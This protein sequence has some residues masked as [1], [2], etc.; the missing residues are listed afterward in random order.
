LKRILEAL[1]EEAAHVV[2]YAERGRGKTSLANTAVERLR[3]VGAMVGRHVCSADSDF[4]QIIHGILRDLPT[5]LLPL[6]P[7][8][9]GENAGRGCDSILP[10]RGLRPADVAE[11]PRRL[12]CDR[13]IF[14]VDEF[15]RVQDKTTRTRL[16][17]T[18]K[19]LSDRGL[20][21]LFM[22]IGVSNT[23]EQIIGQHPSIQRNIA[24]IHL[25]LLH[26][27][28]VR[29]MLVR[30]GKTGGVDFSE[31][32]CGVVAGI[33]RGMPYIAQLMGL[34]I[35]QQTLARGGTQTSAQDV[36]AAVDRLLADQ[37][38]EVVTR[39]AAL[40]SGPRG[41]AMEMALSRVA[42]APQDWL[43]RI[44][45][46]SMEPSLVTALLQ[47][48]VVEPATSLPGTLQL[49]DRPLMNFVLLLA[50]R[51]GSASFLPQ[52]QHRSAVG[53]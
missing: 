11:I 39:Y 28:E 25:P 52:D 33:A 2:I 41:K 32:A 53:G 4:D 21:L 22:I 9:T 7:D 24:G 15:D 50:V 46:A 43:G 3:Q 37:S 19:L 30:G 40:T 35:A 8:A 49:S 16:A 14:V 18:I 51:N 20:K 34:R 26:D 5:S 45:L 27:A 44:N 31:Y 17:D 1:N 13:L 29:A 47:E 12:A 10:A 38:S 42:S 23:L 36:G 6:D 48:K